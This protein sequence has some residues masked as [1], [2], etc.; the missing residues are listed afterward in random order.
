VI[1]K[2]G[3]EGMYVKT[4]DRIYT[5][6]DLSEVWL[7]LDAYESDIQWLHY[8]QRVSVEAEAY[9]GEVFQGKIAFIDPFVNEKTRTIKMRGNVE[10]KNNKLKPGMFVRTTINAQLGEGGKIYEAELA[11]KWICPMHPEIVKDHPGDCDICGMDLVPTKEFG[12]AEKPLEQNKA[13][14]IPASAPLIT[15]QRAVV[16]VEKTDPEGM[17]LY[18]GREVVLGPRAGDKYIVKSGLTEGERVVTK[19]NFKIDSAMQIN[20]KPSMMNPAGY[21]SETDNIVS[22][23]NSA[24]TENAGILKE[25]LPLYLHTSFALSNDDAEEALK[26]FTAFRDK[27]SAIVSDQGL[28]GKTSGIAAGINR[29]MEHL[30]DLKG[31]IGAIRETF[32]AV[33]LILKDIL[34]K[35]E[36]KEDLKLYLAFC[37]M[38]FGNKGAYWLQET[39]EIKN[40][41]FGKQ[42]LTCGEIKKE[43]GRKLSTETEQKPSGGHVH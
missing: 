25:A 17:N 4:G 2:I 12:F 7:Y 26:S 38:A 15:G 41:Y 3:F 16:Y 33:S 13:L 20:A 40:P 34:D 5:I 35:Y 29:I 21:Y 1:Q 18:E 30:A 32:G 24:V 6:A 39:K 11:G 42:M 28:E 22:E 9:P 10:N 43:Y 27:L 37:P 14:V 19:G 31:D 23:T 8:G 36:Y